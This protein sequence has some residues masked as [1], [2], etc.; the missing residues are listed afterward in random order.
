MN[1]R[2]PAKAKAAASSSIVSP[3]VALLQ[4]K[5]ACGS[6]ARLS[7][8]CAECGSKKLLGKDTVGLLGEQ[9]GTL[10]PVRGELR[11][12]SS[13]LEAGAGSSLTSGL[14][15]AFSRVQVHSNTLASEP[16]QLPGSNDNSAQQLTI[17]G[18]LLGAESASGEEGSEGF[19]ES[20]EETVVEPSE[21]GIETGGNA[22]CPVTAV[23]SSTLAGQ[24]KA[25]CRVPDKQFGAATLARF[26][27]HGVQPGAKSQTVTEQFK[28][29]KDNYGVFG[30]L[31][32]NSFT[33]SGSIFDDCYM[34]ASPKPLPG[35]LELQVEQNHLLNGQ[36]ISKNIVTFTPS[37]ISIR[38]CRRL[39]GSCDFASVCRR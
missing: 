3:R 2:F 33:T 8:E 4:R 39:P 31:K 36:I 6:G 21:S 17:K 22:T 10:S 24:E 12:L 37:R 34:L 16:W 29:L 7:G 30:L 26:T 11:A 15:H 23:F 18:Q 1:T 32:P 13:P 38:S 27:L 9:Y 35:D 5:C 28:S 25:N 19:T 20:A 14:G